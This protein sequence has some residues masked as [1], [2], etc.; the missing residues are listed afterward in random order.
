M[1]FLKGNFMRKFLSIVV[2]LFTASCSNQANI[3]MSDIPVAQQNQTINSSANSDKITYMGPNNSTIVNKGLAIKRLTANQITVEKTSLLEPTDE[4]FVIRFSQGRGVGTIGELVMYLEKSGKSELAMRANY[5][6]NKPVT[7]SFDDT[8]TLLKSATN[9]KSNV[10]K[11]GK[12]F[13]N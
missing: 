12:L 4:L 2:L 8:K 6:T 5:H 3:A 13:G 1:S 10:S 7:L 9:Y 11:L